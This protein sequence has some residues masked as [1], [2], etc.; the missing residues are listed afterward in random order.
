MGQTGLVDLE[1]MVEAGDDTFQDVLQPFTP[2]GFRLLPLQGSILTTAPNEG[3]RLELTGRL[4]PEDDP[5]GPTGVIERVVDSGARRA[6]HE[7]FEL[8][9]EW[10]GQARGRVVTRQSALFYD[11][12]GV[13]EVTLTAVAYGRYVWAM[14]GF[15]FRTDE[16]RA[17]VLAAVDE[18]AQI[19]DLS[20]FDLDQV[21]HSWEIAT[22]ESK[23][24][25]TLADIAEATGEALESE[26]AS[27][28]AKEEILPGKAL[29]LF[30]ELPGWEGRLDLSRAGDNPGRDQLFLYTETDG[31]GDD[32]GD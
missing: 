29:L 4:V 23:R 13:E 21:E 14:C 6:R 30:S 16:D 25:L 5:D 24:T 27:A 15:D 11:E 18:F 10:T 31:D 19:L 2:P 8:P 1:A 17:E 9:A 7:K 3:V 32:D 22:I 20:L 26:A 12:L 28:E